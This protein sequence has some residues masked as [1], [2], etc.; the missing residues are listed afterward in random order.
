MQLRRFSFILITW[1]IASFLLG[2]VLDS[3]SRG[4]Q[5]PYT[6]QHCQIFQYAT[7]KGIPCKAKVQ[8]Y[9][10]P[11][12]ALRKYVTVT[13]LAGSPEPWLDNYRQALGIPWY[14]G[15]SI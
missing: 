3:I 14:N 11:V 2:F 1:L 10:W 5:Q 8:Y 9:G 13:T 7:P 6:S 12:P 4:G 15:G